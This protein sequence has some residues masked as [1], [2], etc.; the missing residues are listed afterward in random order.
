MIINID[1]PYLNLLL[2]HRKNHLIKDS[3]DHLNFTWLKD[4]SINDE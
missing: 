1:F 3:F 4:P 2:K